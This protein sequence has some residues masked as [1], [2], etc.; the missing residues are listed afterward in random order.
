MAGDD[1][2]LAPTVVSREAAEGGLAVSLM[3]RAMH[4]HQG[5]LHTML[6]VSTW[7]PLSLR[8]FSVV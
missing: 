1:C 3:E 6:L 5:R 4:L 7:T 2:Q 8:I